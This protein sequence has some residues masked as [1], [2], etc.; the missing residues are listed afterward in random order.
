MPSRWFLGVGYGPHHVLRVQRL[1]YTTE[2]MDGD[3]SNGYIAD[4]VFV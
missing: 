4:T 3:R 1:A 2:A